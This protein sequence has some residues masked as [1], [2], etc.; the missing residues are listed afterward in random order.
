MATVTLPKGNPRTKLLL[1]LAVAFALPVI[2]FGA[3]LVLAPLAKPE[4]G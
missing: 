1:T 3:V 4:H 2:L